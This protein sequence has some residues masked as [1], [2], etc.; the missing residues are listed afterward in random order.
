M[1]SPAWRPSS[2]W[3]APSSPSPTATAS[4][5]ATDRVVPRCSHTPH[6]P[7]GRR[8]AQLEY[9]LSCSPR[10]FAVEQASSLLISILQTGVSKRGRLLDAGLL[11]VAAGAA[12]AAAG[13]AAEAGADDVVVA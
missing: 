3:P 1:D 8:A 11:V 6:R 2:L 13:A 4:C 10:V 5:P 12:E 7:R 9:P